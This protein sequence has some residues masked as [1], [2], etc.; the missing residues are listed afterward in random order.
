MF[1]YQKNQPIIEM[2]ALSFTASG[3]NFELAA[4]FNSVFESIA[5]KHLQ[6]LLGR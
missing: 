4:R 6:E 1:F 2:P 3:N 5:D